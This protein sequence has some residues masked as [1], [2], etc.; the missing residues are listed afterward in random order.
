MREDKEREL[1]KIIGRFETYDLFVSD[2]EGEEL[3]ANIF[4]HKAKSELEEVV[5]ESMIKYQIDEIKTHSLYPSKSE[6]WLSKSIVKNLFP[7]HPLT[8][9]IL[10]R[11]SSEFAQSTRSMFNFLSPYEKQNGS[12]IDFIRSTDV[13]AENGC[14]NLFTPDLLY[15]FF[16]KNIRGS[17]SPWD[18][19]LY[20]SYQQ[21]QSKIQTN[22]GQRLARNLLIFLIVKQNRIKPNDD[23][24]FW[25]MN[26]PEERRHEFYDFIKQLANNEY[27]EFNINDDT[28]SF[29]EFGSIPLTKMIQDEKN[30][31]VDKPLSYFINIWIEKHNLPNI[32]PRQYNDDKGTNRYFKQVIVSSSEEI[33]FQIDT[34]RSFYKTGTKY[35]GNG[36]VLFLVSNS[37]DK[38]RS[39]LR[40]I[41]SEFKEYIIIAK[42]ANYNQ[43][44]SLID[45]TKTLKAIE[46]CSINPEVLNKP[47]KIS[48]LKELESESLQNLENIIKEL[49]SSESW[50]W[51]YRDII[52]DKITNPVKLSRW[53][54]NITQDLFSSTARV[55]DE[56]L[57][58]TTRQQPHRKAAI[59]LIMNSGVDLIPTEGTSPDQRI[60]NNFF[61]FTDLYEFKKRQGN[62]QYGEIQMLKKD[63]EIYSIW[64]LL[65][66]RLSD[67]QYHDP[68][69][70]FSE[71]YQKPFG[72]SNN[73]IKIFMACYLRYNRDRVF[74]FN[75]DR[76]PIK[77]PYKVDLEIIEK[78]V[79]RPNNFLLR[80][81]QTSSKEMYYLARLKKHIDPDEV[82]YSGFANKI[83]DEYKELTIL[84]KS[85]IVNQNDSLIINFFNSLENL[86]DD[87]KSEN[88]N[89]EEISRNF[90]NDEL[91]SIILDINN[92]EEF[93]DDRSKVD[94]LIEKVDRY[95]KLP[96][97][98][99]EMFKNEL[100]ISISKEVFNVNITDASEFDRVANEWFN[101]LPEP[102]KNNLNYST[103]RI[104]DWTKY[105][106]IKGSS[107]YEEIYFS[108]L[109]R[110]PI[111]NW[112]NPSD[113]KYKY[114]LDIKGFKEEIE[115]FKLSA[116]ERLKT[117]AVEVFNC[118]RNECQNEKDFQGQLDNWVSKV[119]KLIFKCILS[120]EVEVL[121]KY[122]LKN[123]ISVKTRFLDI[124]LQ[125]WI[126]IDYL[127]KAIPNNWEEWSKTDEQKVLKCYSNA[128]KK[129]L[130]WEPPFENRQL[131]T[132]LKDL[133]AATKNIE[134]FED[135]KKSILQWHKSLPRRTLLADPKNFH[136][137]AELFFK[138]VLNDENF[139]DS[140]IR[141]CE[142]KWDFGSIINWNEST[143]E[144]IHNKLFSIK[145]KTEK[146]RRP[147]FE[148]IQNYEEDEKSKSSSEN[149][150]LRNISMKVESSTLYKSDVPESIVNNKPATIIVNS[151]K[152]KSSLQ[153]IVEEFARSCKIDSDRH[154]WSDKDE[155]HFIELFKKSIGFI[156]EWK[157]TQK[158]QLKKATDKILPEIL[159]IQ[160]EFGL[161]N[162]QLNIVLNKIIEDINK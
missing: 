4:I 22:E 86:M 149:E 56:A 78:L 2:T 29:P 143:V 83:V 140:L 107:S 84:Q 96:L 5:N 120:P 141:L 52:K 53:V 12:F 47:M 81:I 33:Q 137:D 72:Y 136:N 156:I 138:V 123:D 37:E 67:N 160:K 11:F 114:I 133:F 161:D 139:E 162:Y 145:D 19:S 152:H 25:A 115:E 71:M 155:D 62:L 34:L 93:L 38:S 100:L 116:I 144:E 148:I 8:S 15:M 108:H 128:F 36:I 135:L 24:L 89:I 151:I 91:P 82:S 63:N 95:L 14:V 124:I 28:Y 142:D 73:L 158:E 39:L 60:L 79:N 110:E 69:E 32:Y 23:M 104:N 46:N 132:K 10:I 40:F 111:Y 134:D 6:K 35:D 88:N 112:D 55:K 97:Q 102:N 27:L 30:A 126:S 125:E 117:L 75:N 44:E 147:I 99:L 61:R 76:N 103:H 9:Y 21:A 87:L 121:K 42:P 153:N 59:D 13:K 90:F 98:L 57:N 122:I 58:Y 119:D 127:P 109:P 129:I 3:L 70:M 154:I 68:C 50:I 105:L 101:R 94:D 7:L 131:L 157:D 16:E 17:K 31:L 18:Q 66:E 118:S 1:N 77:R 45:H 43:F 80:K 41:P 65:D 48:R 113:E 150:F 54:N 159:R 106:K 74:V 26:W 51:Y 49:F 64:Q 20:E 92:S 146:W 85:L 130:D